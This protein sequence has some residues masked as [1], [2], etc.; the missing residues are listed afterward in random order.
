MIVTV[1]TTYNGAFQQPI[2]V[3]FTKKLN[4]NYLSQGNRNGTEELETTIS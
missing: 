4:K 2:K 3:A 1:L